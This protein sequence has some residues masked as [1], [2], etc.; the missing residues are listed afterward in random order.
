MFCKHPPGSYVIKLF[1]SVIYKKFIISFSRP[2]NT[3]AKYE[4]SLI[5]TVKCFITLAPGVYAKETAILLRDSA[6]PPARQVK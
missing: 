2:T 5:T 6:N 3:L 4:N 1:L